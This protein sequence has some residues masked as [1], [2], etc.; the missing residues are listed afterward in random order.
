MK[1]NYTIITLQWDMFKSLIIKKFPK[2][3]SNKFSIEKNN[4]SNKV[5]TIIHT[6]LWNT[7]QTLTGSVKNSGN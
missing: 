1:I 3:H 5:G 6:L 2:Y 7:M 4:D